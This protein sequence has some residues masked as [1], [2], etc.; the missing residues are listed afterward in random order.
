MSGTSWVFRDIF[1]IFHGNIRRK[2]KIRQEKVPYHNLNLKSWEPA[3]TPLLCISTTSPNP[4]L[5]NHGR[6][7]SNHSH[8]LQIILKEI[9]EIFCFL[10]YYKNNLLNACRKIRSIIIQCICSF[11]FIGRDFTMWPANNCLQ[12][13]VLLQ[14]IF[15]SCVIETTLLCEQAETSVIDL[16][17]SDKSRYFAHPRSVI[18]IVNY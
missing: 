4:R 18:I 15:C 13:S 10:V 12:I 14:I 6:Q 9:N 16:L 8:T 3:T 2:P 7:K 1:S 17:T 5:P 11:L